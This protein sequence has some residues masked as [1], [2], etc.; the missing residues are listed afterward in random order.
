MTTGSA[1]LN[2]PITN[3]TI[4]RT[5]GNAFKAALTSAGL[6]QTADTGQIDWTTVTK[7]AVASTDAGYEIWRL[8]DSGQTA[9]PI[10]FK[11]RHGTAATSA[12]RMRIQMD[13]GEGSN[14]SGTLTG[15]TV[16]TIWE[17]NSANSGSIVVNLYICWASSIGVFNISDTSTSTNIPT[18]ALLVERYKDAAGAVAD[19]GAVIVKMTDA[20][21]TSRVYQAYPGVIDAESV[22]SLP[23]MWPGRYGAVASQG[24]ILLSPLTPLSGNGTHGVLE[25][26]LGMIAGG[27]EEW[28]NGQTVSLTRW[29]GASHTYKFVPTYGAGGSNST[30]QDTLVQHA[31]LWE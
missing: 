7:P 27:A 16:S 18:Q 8:N 25:K 22:N 11:F 21:T 13:I 24:G 17:I 30:A 29:D 14:G 5:N 2:N 28:L 6:T 26:T 19:R 31:L 10:F 20:T 3:D 15:I 12:D 23:I 9:H 4:F 1:T